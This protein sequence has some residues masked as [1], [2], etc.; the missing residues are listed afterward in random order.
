MKPN[1]PK[2]RAQK[3]VY[4]RCRRCRH[5]QKVHRAARYCTTCRDLGHVGLLETVY[6]RE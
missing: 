2:D 5:L 4:K 1:L 6:G 3:R